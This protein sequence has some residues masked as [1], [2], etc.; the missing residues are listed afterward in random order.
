MDLCSQDERYRQ[1]SLEELGR[2]IG[3]TRELN[4]YFPATTR[5]LLI[6]N[7]GGFSMQEFVGPEERAKMYNILHDALDRVDA[8]GVEILPQT[9]PPFPWHFGGQRFHNLFTDA[10][11]IV[12][13]CESR[14][15]RVCLDIS[16]SK[17][18]CNQAK[19]SFG[20]FLDRVA[21]FAAHLHV[22]DASGVDGEGLQIGEGEIDF[23]ELGSRLRQL[24][25]RASFIPEIWQGHKN[26][27][28]GFW[29]ALDRLE[30]PFS[31]RKQRSA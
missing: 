2:V 17:L 4:K 21:P 16:H 18:A 14:N 6:V 30:E 24:C 25:P 31:S 15:M 11:A 1:R 28:E 8:A 23:I 12:S 9:M 7:V 3:I 5:P 13:F 19:Q 26:E 29:I 20:E 22:V 10:D 27:G